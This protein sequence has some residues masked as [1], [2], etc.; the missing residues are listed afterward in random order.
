MKLNALSVMLYLA[1]MRHLSRLGLFSMHCL[2]FVQGRRHQVP[3]TWSQASAEMPKVYGAS[4]WQVLPQVYYDCRAKKCRANHLIR[5]RRES[6]EIGF[7][8]RE[9]NDKTQHWSL[10]CSPKFCKV[11][12]LSRQQVP[13]MLSGSSSDSPVSGFVVTASAIEQI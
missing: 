13:G 4:R 5:E 11:S 6:K 2:S 1:A 3:P 12:T 9:F 10:T 7:N 8:K